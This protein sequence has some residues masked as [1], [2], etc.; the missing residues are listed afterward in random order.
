MMQD[1]TGFDELGI[2]GFCSEESVFCWRHGG[3]LRH[4]ACMSE[5]FQFAI[6]PLKCLKRNYQ[7]SNVLQYFLS[8]SLIYFK[9]IK[10]F[11]HPLIRRDDNG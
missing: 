7:L 11:Y 1:F 5:V 10:Y 2:P 6:S 8:I 3:I 4:V 9:L